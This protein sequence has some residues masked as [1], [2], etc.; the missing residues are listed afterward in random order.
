MRAI[1]LSTVTRGEKVRHQPEGVQS[2]ENGAAEQ[3]H[4][5]RL[6]VVGSRSEQPTSRRPTNLAAP[7]GHFFRH[8]EGLPC[9]ANTL[10]API[11]S[12]TMLAS[13]SPTIMRR[14]YV[15]RRS[16]SCSWPLSWFGRKARKRF[17]SIPRQ[18]QS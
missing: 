10:S 4:E 16:A 11:A 1:R 9:R 17:R 14:A 2:Q 5:A 6:R 12:A 15:P 18:L 8:L 13:S 7:C 3:D